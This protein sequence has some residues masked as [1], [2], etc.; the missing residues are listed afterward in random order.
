MEWLNYHHLL[1]F[2]AVAREGGLAP[3]GRLL[4]LSHATLSAQIH[5]LEDSLG[6]K[7]L[8][9]QG[10]RLALTDTGR[11]AYRY[12]DEIFSLGRELVD[13]V[14]GR[15]SGR[16]ARLNVG[17][18]DVVPKLVVKRVLDAAFAGD[19]HI[20]LVCHEDS[21]ERLIARMSLHELDIVIADAPV[22][23]GSRVRAFSHLLGESGITFYGA[24]RFTRLRRQFPR[25]L[26][27]APMLLPAESTALRRSLE[28]WFDAVGVR[29][30]V[31]AEFDDM[32][33]MG[34]F[35]TDGLGLFAGPTVVEAE[36]ARQYGVSVIGRTDGVV[37]RFYALSA[38][39]RLENPAV[40]AICESARAEL[41]G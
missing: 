39:R 6:V 26:D 11:T 31:S 5:A 30:R 7:L 19:Q 1:D 18:A 4:R 16:P 23:P 38:E 15:P 21:H 40:V 2:W 29:P 13:V 25:S 34:V 10:R 24:R 3:A 20:Q 35:A 8:Q 17:V 28:L 37:E 41:F 32:A 27:G 33:L 12:A 14:K 36:T 9:R 22:P